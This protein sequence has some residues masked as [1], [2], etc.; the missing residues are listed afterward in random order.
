MPKNIQISEKHSLLRIL[1]I[2]SVHGV[3]SFEKPQ[4]NIY[5]HIDVIVPQTR[6]Y[7]HM[8]RNEI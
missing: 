2:M 1:F 3:C 8:Y 5:L 4:I 7:V 6:M